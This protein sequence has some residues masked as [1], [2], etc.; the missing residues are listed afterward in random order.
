MSNLKN[1]WENRKLILEGVGNTL[2]KNKVIEE[3]AI[4]RKAVCAVC[5]FLNKDCITV[6]GN[7][8]GACGCKIELKTRAMAASCPK[9]KW[10][11]VK[12]NK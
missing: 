10:V 9:N 11:A 2:I 12:V 5:P 1:I 6:G 7:C 8:C 4:E 3:I